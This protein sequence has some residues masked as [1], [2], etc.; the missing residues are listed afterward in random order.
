M[1]AETFGVNGQLVLALRAGGG[2]VPTW[3]MFR[4]TEVCQTHVFQ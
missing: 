4:V 3:Y 2:G 1:S